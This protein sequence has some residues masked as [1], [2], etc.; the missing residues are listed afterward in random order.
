[1]NTS[2]NQTESLLFMTLL[3][4]IVVV[5]A[6]RYMH[7]VF[8]RLGQPGV[9]GEIFSGLLLGPSLVGHFLPQA[10]LAVFGAHASAPITIISQIGYSLFLGLGMAITTPAH[11]WS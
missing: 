6:A 5:G 2:I 10:S 11:S 3:Q 9:T 7:T 8:R 1:M 4:L